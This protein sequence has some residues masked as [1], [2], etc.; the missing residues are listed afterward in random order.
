MSSKE[1]QTTKPSTMGSPKK[2]DE[3]EGPTGAPDLSV[4][5][6]WMQSAKLMAQKKHWEYFVIDQFLRGNQSIRGNPNDNSITISKSNDAVTFPINKLFSTF[7]AVRG[8]VTRHQPVVTVEPENSSDEAKTNARRYNKILERDNQLNNFRKINKEWVYFGVKY[9]IGYRQVGYDPVKKCAIRWSIDPWDLWLGQ[10]DGEMEDSPYIVKPIRRTMAYW[11]D[12]FPKYKDSLS[13]DNELSPD[14][15]KALS[16]QITYQN[17]GDQSS[18]RQE[19]QTKI[20]YEVWYRVYKENKAGGTINKCTFVE[21]AILDHEETPYEDYP[22]IAYKSDIVPNEATG[23]GHLKHV[24][25][26]QRLLNM[27][28]M[29]VVEYNHIVNKGRFITEKNSGFNVMNTNNGQIIRVNTGKR[30]EAAPVP[31]LNP[32]VQ[33]QIEKADSYIQDLGGQQDASMG[34]LPSA[35]ISGDA[36]EALQ[37]GDS[38]NISDLRDN[39]EDALSQEA[40]WILKLYSLFEADGFVIDNEV[41]EGKSEK[42]GVVGQV[43]MEKAQRGL[44]K[45][46]ETNKDAYFSEDNGDYCEACTVL[47]DN[48]V[49]VTV[50]SQ[51]GETRESR[52]NL[53]FKLLEAGMPLKTLLEFLEFPNVSDMME[54]IASEGVADMAMQGMGAQMSQPSMPQDPNAIQGEAP[55]PPPME[56]MGESLLEGEVAA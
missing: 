42:F 55:P 45:N 36:I 23:E 21:E 40:A 17:Q 44:A 49:K 56:G 15:Y 24:I 48:Q 3:T 5:N 2:K 16:L 20:G 4:L 29:Q 53:L 32:I 18:I 13:P 33:W 35:S 46:P 31:A 19:E 50:T 6:G 38:N 12:K 30:L 39:F 14:E 28:N 26:P 11:W 41:K 7:R 27:L 25:A 37:Q 9:G 51:L 43:A 22:F 10:T 34:R 54:R 8:F 1:K 52:I 47:P